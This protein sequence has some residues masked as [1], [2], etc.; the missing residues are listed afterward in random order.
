M[1]RDRFAILAALAFSALCLCGAAALRPGI[2]SL[3]REERLTAD[4]DL[5]RNMPPSLAATQALGSF[6]GLAID[7]LWIRA[8]AQAEEG[9]YHEA[10]QT[11][12]WIG[13]LMPRYP[14]VWWFQG[15]QMLAT[16]S[17]STRTKEER[18]FW[19]QQ[20]IAVMRDDGLRF[21]PESV[22]L[23]R[24][25]SEAYMFRIG[26]YYSEDE[27]YHKKM[28]AREW[29]I[30][31]GTPRLDNDAAELRRLQKIADAPADFDEFEAASP[32][33]HALALALGYDGSNPH[34]RQELLRVIAAAE[35]LEFNEDVAQ[36]AN[37]RNRMGVDESALAT[38]QAAGSDTQAAVSAFLRAQG[39][40][41]DKRVDPEFLVKLV[42][43]Y[44][45][46]DWR[47]PAAHALYWAAKGFDVGEHMRKPV[48]EFDFMSTGRAVIQSLRDLV[49][50]GRVTF[51][52]SWEDSY[53]ESPDPRLISSAEK[54]LFDISLRQGHP[55]GE[56]P[57]FYQDG[58]RIFLLQ[59]VGD[60]YLWNGREAAAPLYATLK[61]YY[62]TGPNGEEVY[63]DDLETFAIANRIKDLS[64]QRNN[65]QVMGEIL[66]RAVDIGLGQ[67]G[68]NLEATRLFQFA[69]A[70]HRVQK[71]RM[72]QRAAGGEKFKYELPVFEAYVATAL[73]NYLLNPAVPVAN[74]LRA[75][76][77]QAW[78]K[79]KE[80]IRENLFDGIKQH[81]YQW[82]MENGLDPKAA[83]PEPPDMEEF[84]KQK[85]QEEI[86]PP[87]L[88]PK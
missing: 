38:F 22:R 76:N 51:Q 2:D 5:Y 78:A 24:G 62:G 84:R 79:S 67:R 87:V 64:T 50:A 40:R 74:K 82:A 29:Q 49:K 61:K 55:E 56:V 1:N 14:E 6:R 70:I 31:L 41:L 10:V 16:I 58:H 52:L 18:W 43:E 69:R 68:R 20:G 65:M 85:H 8:T 33:G 44:G 57:L 77:S 35:E 45:A 81:L 75:W 36:G 21:C 42:K 86:Q 39:L 13:T 3:R 37:L 47:H 11:A 53:M 17:P 34:K 48:D 4:P 28:H 26:Q 72:D 88:T 60:A 12:R 71:E 59:A 9:R 32:E 25:I 54:A 19:I 63:K 15:N 7:Y 73:G 27:R 46:I 83:F 23:Y 30:A 80:P 66:E